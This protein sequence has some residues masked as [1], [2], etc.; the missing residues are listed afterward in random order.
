MGAGRIEADV[1]AVYGG[2]AGR[3][4]IDAYSLGG[5]WTY[6][7]PSGGYLDGVLQGA[8]YDNA[9]TRSVLGERLKT[10]GWGLTASLEAGYPIDLGSGWRIEPQAQIIYQ[11]VSFEG[12]KDRFGQVSYDGADG[13]HVRLG[14]RL[15]RN[16][17]LSGTSA[18]TTWVRANLWHSFDTSA[19]AEFKN[20]S[21]AYP[22][23]FAT[24]PG[25]TWAQIGLGASAQIS[26][27]VSLFASADYNIRLASQKGQG[28]G[29]RLGL[30]VRW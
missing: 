11:H 8:L 29:G 27:N 7:G 26:D 16:W 6:S 9:E 1:E 3:A 23:A 4:T 25:G 22:V 15:T 12:G 20:L 10:R 30:T 28:A 21:G 13:L 24:D 2:K 19:G 18:L 17:S 5:Y 14:T